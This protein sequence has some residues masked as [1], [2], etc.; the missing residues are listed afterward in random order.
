MIPI[1]NILLLLATSLIVA[2]GNQLNQEQDAAEATHEHSHDSEH[3]THEHSH[4]T[5]PTNT[6]SLALNN[7]AKWEADESTRKHTS[8]LIKAT[9][10]FEQQPKKDL[11]AY[12]AFADEAQS[13]LQEL[14]NGCTMEGPNHDALHLWL[15][16]V[17]NDVKNLKD[18]KEETTAKEKATVLTTDIKKYPQFFN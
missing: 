5:E 16:P 14:I 1:K 4:D 6:T 12:H 7:G 3:A 18:C 13:I 17:L 2:C 15:E 8:A 10:A 9:D 11:A